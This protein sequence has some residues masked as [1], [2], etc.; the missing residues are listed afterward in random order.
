M[1]LLLAKNYLELQSI[2]Y[3]IDDD[4]SYNA[5]APSSDDAIERCKILEAVD[6]LP[7]HDEENRRRQVINPTYKDYAACISFMQFL[8][9]G[10]QCNMHVTFRSQSMNHMAYDADTL[11]M[12]MDRYLDSRCSLYHGKIYVTVT[13]L[14]LHTK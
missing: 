7:Y 6:N 12:C 13:S 5:T 3:I 11:I 10:D 1:E 9:T 2:S 8:I 14:H 4:Q